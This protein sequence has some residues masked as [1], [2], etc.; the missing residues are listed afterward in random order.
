MKD[1]KD[2]TYEEL[3]KMHNEIYGCDI[4]DNRGDVRAAERLGVNVSEVDRRYR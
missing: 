3:N 2:Y 4:P 1:L